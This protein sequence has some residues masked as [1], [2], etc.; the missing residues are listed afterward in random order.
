MPASPK[1]KILVVAGD[2]ASRSAKSRVLQRAGFDVIE[3]R[4]G[5]E[6]LHAT[7][8][9]N[10]QLVLLD[11]SL[12]DLSGPEVCRQI[13]TDPTTASTFVLLMSVA[14][15]ETAAQMAELAS[16]ADSYLSELA[17]S[18][19]LLATIQALLRIQQAEEE[20]RNKHAILSAINEV[21]TD[22][23][24]VKDL[25]GR[26]LMINPAGARFL[27]KQ[28]EEVIGKD[29]RE[30]FP[31]ET[32]HAI[33]QRDRQIMTSGETSTFEEAA[34]MP[35]GARVF[36]STKAPYFNA[37]RNTIGLL[38]IARDITQLKR[39]EESLREREER[40]R[41]ALEAARLGT[42][43]WDII[44]DRVVWSENLERA[45]GFAPG[46]FKG[47]YAAFLELVHPEDRARIVREV[48][49]VMEEGDDFEVEFRALFPRGSTRWT[50]A[51][52]QVFR[53]PTG[54]AV[55]LTGVNRDIT[56]QKRAEEGRAR[57]LER[58]RAAR[59]EA[60]AANRLKDEF[61]ATVS[62]ELRTPLNA[63][64]GWLYLLRSGKLDAATTAQAIEAVDRNTK[65]QAQLIEDILDVSRI[66][67]GK[68]RL[69]TSLVELASIIE[70]AIEVVRP[71]AE[72]KSIRVEAAFDHTA[73]PVLGDANRLQQV[74]W[75]L[76]SNAIKFTPPGGRVEIR[77]ARTGAQAEI[78]VSDSGQGIKPEFLPYVFD[79]FRQ[80]DS[81][82]TRA[83]TGLGLG[84]SIVRHLVE[85]HGGTVRAASPGEGQGA[86]FTMMIPLAGVK[87]QSEP[88]QGELQEND[89]L[90][91]SAAQPQLQGLKVLL[92]DDEPET[93]E[94]LV[95]MLKHYHADVV[96]ASSTAEALE[97]IARFRP[98]ALVF[99]LG[100][101]SEDGY[102]LIRQIRA[103]EP[104]SGGQTPAIALIA[105]AR[106]E[107][108]A[109]ALEA[110][111]HEQL[112]KPVAPAQL[113][114]AIARVLARD[115]QRLD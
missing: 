81:S 30:L 98:D 75:N 92:V 62:H 36:L 72:A 12:P 45:F 1:V 33:Q 9:E 82:S 73:G 86:T 69:D 114:T 25:A 113:A 91:L 70:G 18:A 38:G 43:D 42:W 34:A 53:D 95:A 15:P 20:L 99:D 109:R 46:A 47:T 35:E 60:E 105:C 5:Q 74:I 58:E 79:R 24:F 115:A 106:A 89:E 31:A 49:R 8:A 96:S 80:G 87:E 4:T 66:I 90:P 84:L 32:A 40:L 39:A 97:A 13:K 77:L 88:V 78:T 64:L 57:L 107:D 50:A 102:G 23:I 11:L 83:H 111:Y 41:L 19:G 101:P 54:K 110:G 52:G 71:A 94:M 59:A 37:Q 16:G 68:L 85:L 112:S 27:G 103:L 2:E 63:I 17:G 104:K 100:S 48:A 61:L 29:D 93:R 56:K 55:R 22:A 67:T 6:A 21:T 108:G 10:P 51:R 65:T 3:A 26:Y 44:N 76:L 14:A 7:K 28:V